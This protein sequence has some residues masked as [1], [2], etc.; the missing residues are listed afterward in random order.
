MN[1]LKIIENDIS[2]GPGLRMSLF[3]SGCDVHC[4][5]CFNKSS[6]NFEA[7]LPFDD[8]ARENFFKKFE[9]RK[10]TYVG[11]SILGGDP[12][13]EQNMGETFNLI[14]EF[15]KRYP[16]KSVWVWTGHIFEDLKEIDLFA[17][18]Y[19]NINVIVDGPFIEEKAAPLKYMGSSNQRVIRLN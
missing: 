5:G 16:S 2:N 9:N 19:H 1:Y 8:K 12:F 7:G 11:I 4:P 3:V 18:N 6:W 15:K 10:D 14:N 13:A 17:K